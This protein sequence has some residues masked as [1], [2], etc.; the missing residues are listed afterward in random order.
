MAVGY[1]AVL[2]APLLDSTPT[3]HTSLRPLLTPRHPVVCVHAQVRAVTAEE[4]V[5]SSEH[6]VE[7]MA[8]ER[9]QA[10]K[11]RDE[12]HAERRAAEEALRVAATRDE[13]TR[14]KTAAESTRAAAEVWNA[15]L[16]EDT[17]RGSLASS[18]PHLL[19][20]SASPPPTTFSSLSHQVREA[21]EAMD[22]AEAKRRVAVDHLLGREQDVGRLQ[23]EVSRA[24]LERTEMEA[25]LA[26]LRAEGKVA[27]ERARET[28]KMHQ[29]Q[30]RMPA[31]PLS[32]LARPLAKGAFALAVT[33]P[34]H[35]LSHTHT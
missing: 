25:Q 21:K 2:L 35:P 31:D 8:K 1:A 16:L 23:A 22:S 26:S 27:D 18:C 3:H 20:L 11:E 12:A 10:I 7:E 24:T 5:S 32:P 33:S 28:E 17:A 4:R 29:A 6:K 15:R 34:C 30:A 19:F 14:A 13:V 9:Q